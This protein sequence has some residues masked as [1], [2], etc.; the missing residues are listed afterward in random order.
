MAPLEFEKGQTVGLST[1]P[2]V[3][4]DPWLQALFH[5]CG[6]GPYEVLNTDPLQGVRVRA[7]T[8][9][10]EGREKWVPPHCLVPLAPEPC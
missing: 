4:A 5:H 6:P 3:R 9:Q 1:E 2:S 8:G 7:N 10:K